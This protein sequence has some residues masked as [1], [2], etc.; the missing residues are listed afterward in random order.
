M[1]GINGY[2]FYE[3]I[4]L[5]ELSNQTSDL[6][7]FVCLLDLGK[8]NISDMIEHFS[9][10]ISKL[11]GTISLDK[12]KIIPRNSFLSQKIKEFRNILLRKKMIRLDFCF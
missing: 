11:N 6:K 1:Y 9:L 4:V 7:S 3:N 12:L 8:F 2:K 5:I 10:K